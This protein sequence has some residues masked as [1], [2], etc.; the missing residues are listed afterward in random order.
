MIARVDLDRAADRALGH[1]THEKSS[2]GCA[3]ALATIAVIEEE[4]LLGRARELGR[5]GLRRL[6]G[7]A[8]R[9]P[10]LRAARGMGLHL[11]LEVAE[12]DAAE[13]ILYRCL[14]DGL[15]FKLGGGNV[16][17]LCPPLTI[18]AADLDRA[19]AIL[20]GAIAQLG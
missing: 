18:E 20:E 1:Y 16:V 5:H 13:R 2:L 10:S 11:G 9:W 7:M 15:S 12:A 4:G 17:T 3:A 8:A 19:L 14:E 6:E